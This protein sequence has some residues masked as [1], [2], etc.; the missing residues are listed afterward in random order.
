M[1][2][3]FGSTHQI[4]T[5]NRL[6]RRI[7]IVSN[8]LFINTSICRAVALLSATASGSMA[9]GFI[10][11]ASTVSNGTFNAASLDSITGFVF[12]AGC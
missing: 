6:S 1:H 2:N 11:I 10:K 4:A 8:S 9:F 12:L 3:L 5:Y 7:S